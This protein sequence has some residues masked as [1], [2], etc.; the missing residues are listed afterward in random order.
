ME[1]LLKLNE[2]TYG[3]LH[4]NKAQRRD[5]LCRRLREIELSVTQLSE[6]VSATK[7]GADYTFAQLS[8]PIRDAISE[9]FMQ[10]SKVDLLL[11]AR[12]LAL[13]NYQHRK[14]ELRMDSEFDSDSIKL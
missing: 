13:E 2:E 8:E 11:T 5:E 9:M 14:A 12:D 4:K 1:V 10:L 7:L 3:Y 6:W